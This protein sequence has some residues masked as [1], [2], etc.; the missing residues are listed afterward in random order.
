MHMKENLEVHEFSLKKIVENLDRIPSNGNFGSDVKKLTPEEKKR[1]MELVS[2]FNEY[3]SVLRCEHALMQT[4]KT[5]DEIA[6][7]AETYA[8]T[9]SSDFFQGRV[10]ERDFKQVKGIT[11]DFKKLA[12]E[13]YGKIQ[14][15]NA[16]YEDMGHVLGRY[17]EISSLDEI[18]QSVGVP[19]PVGQPAPQ[20]AAEQPAPM[21]EVVNE[22]EEVNED[23]FQS[24]LRQQKL[25]PNLFTKSQRPQTLPGFKRDDFP[26]NRKKPVMGSRPSAFPTKQP[27][28]L[29]VGPLQ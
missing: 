21:E 24:I 29:K 16:L 1:L 2:K 20:Q 5:L 7:M 11:K 9:E 3:G 8:M 13:C 19:P 4:A 6:G 18:A 26:I 15:L 17:Y 27:T 23:D 10:V 22:S 25:D 12:S 28:S 14:Q